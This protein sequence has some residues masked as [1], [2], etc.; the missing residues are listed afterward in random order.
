M[1]RTLLSRVESRAGRSLRF[2]PEALRALLSY[3]WPGNVRELE[4]AL[5]YAATVARGQTLQPEDLP[6]EVQ[7]GASGNHLPNVAPALGTVAP[8]RPEVDRGAIEAA[9]HAHCWSRADTARALGLSRSTLWRR[10]RELGL[11]AASRSAPSKVTP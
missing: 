10:M 11:V 3:A 4:N 9:L 5:E 2:S 6:P 7:A 8:V 1:A